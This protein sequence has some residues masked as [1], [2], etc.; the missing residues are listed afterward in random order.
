MGRRS[1]DPAQFP[2]HFFQGEIHSKMGIY[3]E[4]DLFVVRILEQIRVST[5]WFLTIKAWGKASLRNEFLK[6]Q[7]F[8]ISN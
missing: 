6:R 7:E 1:D 4:D 2:W 5:V 3:R 8:A